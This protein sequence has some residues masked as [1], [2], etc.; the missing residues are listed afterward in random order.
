MRERSYHIITFGCQMNVHDSLWLGRVLQRRGFAEG[1]LEEAQVV[2]V[3]TC[4]VREKPEQKVMSALGRIRQATNSNPDVLVVVTGCV[5]QQLGE[6]LFRQPQV[7]LVAGS[8]GIASAPEAIERLLAEP[9]RKLSLLDFTSSYEERE[10]G[11]RAPSGPVAYVN[12][13]QGRSMQALTLS[14]AACLYTKKMPNL[15]MRTDAMR[16]QSLPAAV[17]QAV[18]LEG[19]KNERLLRHYPRLN[20]LNVERTKAFLETMQYYYQGDRLQ[21]YDKLKENWA[22]FYPLYYFLENI[23]DDKLKPQHEGYQAEKG[24][25]N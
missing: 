17:E 19:L 10:E 3:N 23:P 20:P 24:G 11:V 15:L 18:A 22:G 5:A 16:N 6:E 21:A 8:D 7:R 14:Y 25:V 4:S 9:D 2:V 12:I 1:S 13:M